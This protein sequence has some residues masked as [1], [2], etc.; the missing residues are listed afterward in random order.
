[1]PPRFVDPLRTAPEVS[2]GL[3]AR[4]KALRLARNWKRDTLA[5]RAGVSAASLKRFET[6]GKVSLE[7]LLKLCSALGR[8][9]ELDQILEPPR[10]LTMAELERDSS[11]PPPKR[12]RK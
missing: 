7:N 4:L 12:G 1:M 5:A 3:A 8:L 9:S 2:R 10:A 11:T 6:S